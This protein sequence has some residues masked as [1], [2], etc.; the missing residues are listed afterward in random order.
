MYSFFL[1]FLEDSVDMG[2]GEGSG[3]DDNINLEGSGGGSDAD[4]EEKANREGI[5]NEITHHIPKRPISTNDESNI[6]LRDPNNGIS[7]G[8]GTKVFSS[9]SPN[10]HSRM[11]LLKAVVSYMFPICIIWLGGSV[12][13]WL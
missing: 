12:S 8:G 1:K 2:S 13:E 5:E 4:R 11:S 9:G 6:I 7:R 3:N 10:S